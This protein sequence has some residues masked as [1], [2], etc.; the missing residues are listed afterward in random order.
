MTV[1]D[2]LMEFC[3]F[4]IAEGEVADPVHLGSLFREYAG[5]TR[6][7]SLKKTLELVRSFGIKIE[8]VDYLDSGGT[9]MSARGSWHIHYAAKDRTGTQKFDIFHELFEIIHKEFGAVDSGISSMIEPKLSQHADRFAASALIPPVFFLEQVG[10]TGCDLVKLG[11]E[12]GLSHQCL[13]IALGQHHTDIPLI[14]ALYEH[15]PKTPA[16]EKA[17]T[18]DFVATVVVK[19]GRARR[20]KNLCWVQTVPTRHSR[21]QNA[22]LV[23]AAITG[24]KS[25]LWRSPQ[26][27][28]SPA[29]LVRPL[30]TSSLEPYRVILLAVPSEECGM[31]TPQLELLEPV[32]VNGD[33]FCPS[34][35]RCHN[36][37]RCSWRLP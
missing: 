15:Q 33:H 25:L 37:I 23:C 12:L 3:R 9:N 24:G 16:I 27:E 30:F 31:L 34:E 1:S 7:P 17:Q 6:T 22:S 8:G 29:V 4:A 5:T 20:T 19:T 36:L 10:R 2:R 13:M 35:K 32:S 14:G 11:E 26:I 18:D 21:P 28:N